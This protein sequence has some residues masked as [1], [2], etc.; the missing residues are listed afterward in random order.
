MKCIFIVFHGGGAG[1]SGGRAGL[2]VTVSLLVRSPAPPSLSVEV[3]MSKAPNPDCSPRAGWRLAWLTPP[4]VCE[5]VYDWVNVRQYCKALGGHWLQNALYNAVRNE[6]P[7][8]QGRD[9]G[10]K[11][12]LHDPSARYSSY[13]LTE[14][15]YRTNSRTDGFN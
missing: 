6:Q 9:D 5:C 14:R 15:S 10:A 1:R 8:L 13:K 3:S 11:G 4:S 7:K 12:T 2:L